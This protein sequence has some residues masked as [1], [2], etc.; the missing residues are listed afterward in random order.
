[1]RFLH[2]RGADSA[3]R[4]GRGHRHL[5]TRRW[6]GA[7]QATVSESMGEP[8]RSVAQNREVWQFLE[9][10]FIARV[11][12]VAASRT[13]EVSRGRHMLRGLRPPRHW[14]IDAA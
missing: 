4:R 14:I 11:T 5:G 1:M 2:A 3:N 6:D 8:R 10:A 7:I 13:E 9:A 12:W